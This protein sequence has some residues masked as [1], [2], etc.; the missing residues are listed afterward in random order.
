MNG[1]TNAWER[2]SMSFKYFVTTV[3]EQQR[4]EVD[5]KVEKNRIWS[6]GEEKGAIE[7]A[8]SRVSN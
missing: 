3:S 8:G 2:A 5:S 1:E 6:T 7:R 4:V